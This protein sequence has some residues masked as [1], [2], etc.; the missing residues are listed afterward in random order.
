[1]L[2]EVAVTMLLP[3]VIAFFLGLYID[4]LLSTTPI[5]AIIMALLGVFAGFYIMYRRYNK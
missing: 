3:I 4:K 5:I 2:I 1:M